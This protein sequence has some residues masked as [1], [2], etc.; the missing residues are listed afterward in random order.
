MCSKIITEQEVI[1][2]TYYTHKSWLGVW[3]TLYNGNIIIC[4]I[5]SVC[6]Y[7]SKVFIVLVKMDESDI[8]RDYCFRC[9]TSKLYCWWLEHLPTLFINDV[10]FIIFDW[11]NDQFIQPRI[12]LISV[13]THSKASTKYLK[14]YTEHR[15]WI[16]SNVNFC[17]WS[18]YLLGYEQMVRL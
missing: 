14:R 6:N 2:P 1:V 16:R 3:S 11:L 4:D 8:L 5:V 9:D 18:W 12:K 10:M 17:K 7:C 15:N 13:N